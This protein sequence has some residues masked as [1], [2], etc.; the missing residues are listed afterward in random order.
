MLP[1]WTF[2]QK[3]SA[4]FALVVLLAL[5]IAVA[6]VYALRSVV[7]SNERLSTQNVQAL[8]DTERMHAFVERKVAAG[9]GFMLTREERFTDRTRE[10]RSEFL[11]L[12]DKLKRTVGSE[13]E[14]RLVEAIAQAEAEHQQGF[15]RV[16]ALLR[17]GAAADAVVRAFDDWVSP[18]R[19]AL[20]VHLRSFIASEE[21]ALGEARQATATTAATAINLMVGIAVTLVALAIGV[22]FVL[23]RT[24]G[25]Q[26]G[27][28]VGHVQSSSS[29]LQ[30]TANQQATGAKEQATAMAEINTTISEL[31]ATSRQ[32]AES[33]QRVAH[34]AG[35]TV[36]A[37]RSGEGTVE[38]AHE[39]IA[40]IRR[41][42]DMI[43]G[44]MLELGKKSQQI[45]AVLD[46]V[47]ELAEQTN[48]LAINATIEAAGA[49]D[50]GKRFAVVADEIR[51]LADR[52]AG[53]TKEIRGLIDD[54]RSAVNTTVMATETGSK[55]VD[56]GTAQFGEVT[57]AFKQ[58][59]ALVTATTEA[60]REIE[61]ST[62]QQ[63]SGVE[64]VN[65]AIAN[66]AQTTRETEVSAGQTLD[67]VSQL[68]SL[69]KDLLRLVQPQAAT[70]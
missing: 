10:A 15:E 13:E 61:L 12:V 51:E 31:L 68:A 62:K 63:A 20:D 3:I 22:A 14:R 25:R 36:G 43:V 64:Q 49:G 53:S 19:D 39:S 30:A 52:V 38:Q 23:A 40:G 24:L 6:S 5:A 59:A 44:H 17:S 48:I 29:E 60:A 4:G 18:K 33:A 58:I 35:Q 9:R 21:R 8:L 67:T 16:F 41:Q 37:A 32:I 56:T 1:H 70:A 47:S 66:V 2:A 7:A 45:G 42:V 69:S 46:I 65:L 28:A 54:V 34:I 11:A 57:T 26:I 50:A 55:A 27:T